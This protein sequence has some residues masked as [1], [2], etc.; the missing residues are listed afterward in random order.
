MQCDICPRRCNIDRSKTKGFCGMGD[1]P[2]VARA[3][4]HMWEE[5]CISGTRGSGAVFF[6][7]C[8]LKCIYCQNYEISHKGRGREVSVRE[9][10]DIFISLRDRGAHNIN[11]VT[12]TH[13]APA[14]KEALGIAKSG[15]RAADRPDIPPVNVPDDEGSSSV[16]SAGPLDI[17]VIYNTSGYDSVNQLKSIEEHVDVYLPDL[18]YMSSEV[19]K[20]YSGA[21]D[22][23]EKASAAVLEMY[24]QK[25]SPVFDDDGIIKKGV[26]IRH[27]VLPG[28]TSETIRL[29]EWISANISKDAYVSLMSQYVPC[30]LA[31]GHNRIGRRITSHEYDKVVNKFIRLGLN[32]YVQ[33]R[34]SA[35]EE[36]IP[37]FDKIQ[38]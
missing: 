7:G 13:F 29:L 5:P 15:S 38:F 31:C 35:S 3:F 21:A 25:G 14:I 27:L 10:A 1:R 24:R 22:Y 4:L 6:S 2:V 20:S 19:S 16:N 9:L 32:G 17:P 28:H 26:I 8:S 37:D 18:K 30:H 11:L 12:P 34:E 36:Y 23:F 33:E